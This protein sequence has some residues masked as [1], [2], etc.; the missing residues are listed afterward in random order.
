MAQVFTINVSFIAASIF[1][2]CHHM[3]DLLEEDHCSCNHTVRI[4]ARYVFPVESVQ[5]CHK[6]RGPG[7][8]HNQ[9]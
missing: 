1:D 8:T 7:V 9:W 2:R 3:I 6:W 5:L 4:F